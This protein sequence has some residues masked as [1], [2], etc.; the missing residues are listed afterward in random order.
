MKRKK[1]VEIIRQLILI[2]FLIFFSVNFEV[3][4]FAKTTYAAGAITS[5]QSGNWNDSNTWVGGVVPGD[6]DT[7]TIANGNTVTV[8]TNTTVGATAGAAHGVLISGSSIFSYGKLVV[9]DGVTLTL[10]GVDTTWYAM[11]ISRYGQFV[12]NPG[13]I[14]RVDATTDSQTG[15]L[16]EGILD[17]RGTEAKPITF[18]VPADHQNWNTTQALITVPMSSIGSWTYDKD[19]NIACIYLP[20][21]RVSNATGTGI[22]SLGNSSISISARNP[23]TIMQT[24]VESIAAIDSAGKYYV[25]YASGTVYFYHSY[26]AGNPSFG[27]TYKY[28]DTSTA[29]WRGWFIDMGKGAGNNI[30]Y[31]EGLF[32]HSIFEYMGSQF[33]GGGSNNVSALRVG[34]KNS[35]QSAANRNFYVKNS[36]FRWGGASLQ[37]SYQSAGTPGDPLLVDN[38][39]FLGVGDDAALQAGTGGVAITFSASQVVNNITFSN[40]TIHNRDFIMFG[41]YGV[42]NGFSGFKAINNNMWGAVDFIIDWMPPSVSLP[43]GEISGNNVDGAGT[44]GAWTRLILDVRGTPGH[45]LLIHNNV[46]SHAR[47]GIGANRNLRI[48]NNIFYQISST[49]IINGSGFSGYAPDVKIQNNLF[50]GKNS[51]IGVDLLI[52]SVGLTSWFEDWTISNNT[53][54]NQAQGAIMMGYDWAFGINSNQNYTGLKIANNIFYGGAYALKRSNGSAKEI[55]RG[56]IAQFDNNNYYGQTTAPFWNINRMATFF[57]GSTNYNLDST[58]NIPGVELWNP[59]YSTNQT[60]RN[61]TLNIANRDVDETLAWG[62]GTPQ[63][64][65]LQTGALTADSVRTPASWATGDRWTITDGSK[66][67]TTVEN[68]PACPVA[69]FIKFTSGVAAGQTFAILANTATTLKLTPIP[70]TMPAIGDSYTIYNSEV[71]LDDG[72]GGTIQAGIDPRY[73]PTTSKVDV[74]I[75]VDVDNSPTG[76][77][78]LVNKDGLLVSDYKILPGSASINT[79]TSVNAA[80]TD[81]WGTIRPQGAGY[82]IGAHEFIAGVSLYLSADKNSVKSGDIITYSINYVN[83][84]PT[85]I[86]NARIEDP[87]PAGTTFISASAGGTSDGAKVIWNLGALAAGANGTVTFEVRVQ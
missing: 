27:I 74:S 30:T 19:K 86:S 50:Y 53:F 72:S 87:L 75:T 46:L 29:N 34:Y 3:F 11:K 58:R 26:A 52:P 60:G 54:V 67:W 42:E 7:V 22:G 73:L 78:K 49:G 8:T 39:Q 28:L 41:T 21:Q 12:L 57:R 84:S 32:D 79:G 33:S 47:Q 5:R 2:I 63:Q 80:A 83:A 14:V 70:A 40:N 59:S 48:Y 23:A 17:A 65:I 68:D 18:T 45:P 81:F 51:S 31:N 37:F 35:P 10:K 43:D 56:G 36:I 85:T 82:D 20:K 71:S 69:K 38:N 55:V 76:D 1:I 62:G 61:L 16:N 64:L 25:D 4:D 77:P 15:I 9:N 24:E 44:A 13:A 66:N 6:G